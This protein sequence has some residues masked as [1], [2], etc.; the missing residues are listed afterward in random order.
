MRYRIGQSLKYALDAVLGVED[1]DRE[2]A[3]TAEER[4][5]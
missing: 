5:V 2:G 1:Q 4:D 3:G